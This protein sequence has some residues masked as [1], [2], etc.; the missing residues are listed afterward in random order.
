MA[1]LCYFV[2]EAVP[3]GAFLPVARRSR[4]ST[5][6]R[7]LLLRALV[8]LSLTM[9]RANAPARNRGTPRTQGKDKKSSLLALKD[10]AHD[11]FQ[12]EDYT[13]VGYNAKEIEPGFAT[14]NDGPKCQTIH[15]NGL[16]CSGWV[17]PADK[18]AP[19]HCIDCLSR[20]AAALRRMG[21][22]A[23]PYIED[24]SKVLYC[25]DELVAPFVDYH[26]REV[27]TLA[28]AIEENKEDGVAPLSTWCRDKLNTLVEIFLPAGA[29][30]ATWKIAEADLNVRS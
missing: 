19:L 26:T 7:L 18:D 10:F 22:D 20:K 16:S 3:S 5:L 25:E 21:K 14:K 13:F 29:S 17:L 6:L 15:E 28:E 11:T 24:M 27:C 4:C 12:D 30:A 9:M 2:D 23:S 1:S 8:C